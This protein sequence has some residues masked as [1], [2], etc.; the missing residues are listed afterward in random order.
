MK[1]SQM[2]AAVLEMWGFVATPT[3][4]EQ[5]AEQVIGLI[6]QAGLG[7]EPEEERWPELGAVVEAGQVFLDWT[8]PGP[9]LS[10]E[11]FARIARC[12]N[13]RRPGGEMENRLRELQGRLAG[14]GIEACVAFDMIQ[15]ALRLGVEEE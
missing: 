2:K 13:A 9:G 14:E 7:W 4:R 11:A 1:R 3:W 12:W 15:A 10:A 5:K 8:G 6:E